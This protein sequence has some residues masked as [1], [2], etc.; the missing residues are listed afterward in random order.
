MFRL[1]SIKSL[2]A[3]E[4]YSV[5]DLVNEIMDLADSTIY[6]Y[7][8]G[9]GNPTLL[10]LN[11]LAEGLTKLLNRPIDIH[12]LVETREPNNSANISPSKLENL[13]LQNTDN[14]EII[15]ALSSVSQT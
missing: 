14:Y 4:G 2:L 9:E 11:I 3:E 12:E 8:R 6:K 5:Q 15:K 10:A 1:K 13:E 7:A